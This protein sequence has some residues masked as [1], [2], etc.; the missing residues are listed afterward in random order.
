MIE[1]LF[2]M[3]RNARTEAKDRLNKNDF[4]GYSQAVVFAFNWKKFAADILGKPVV[5]FEFDDLL[6]DQK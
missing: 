3:Y 1:E 6:T 5:G 2:E 4:S